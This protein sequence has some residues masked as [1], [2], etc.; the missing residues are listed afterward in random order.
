[1]A[2]EINSCDLHWKCILA[3]HQF[4]CEFHV[5]ARSRLHSHEIHAREMSLCIYVYY[6][7]V[8]YMFLNELIKCHFHVVHYIDVH[9]YYHVILYPF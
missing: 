7:Y 8:K 4:L 3:A 1:M 2:R 5:L 6:I 9:F